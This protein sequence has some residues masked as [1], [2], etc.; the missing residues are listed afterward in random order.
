MKTSFPLR[1]ILL[2]GV[3]ATGIAGAAE[4]APAAPAAADAPREFTIV[5]VESIGPRPGDIDTF[6]RI[7]EVFTRVIKERKWPVKVKVERFAS[8]LPAY[9]TVLRVFYKGIHEEMPGELTFRAWMILEDHGEKHD[10]G[11][12][13]YRYTPRPGEPVEDSLQNTIRGAARDVA[14][15]IEPILFPKAG[16]AKP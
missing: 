10:F 9:E 16:A 3:L 4:T 1:S 15:K 2:A 5:V 14:K 6:D 8:N 7:A 11:I 13:P 12:I